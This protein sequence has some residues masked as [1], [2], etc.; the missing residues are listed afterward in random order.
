MKTLP[1][2]CTFTNDY[3]PYL[4]Q[5]IDRIIQPRLW[6]SGSN[7]ADYPDIGDWSQRV[8]TELRREIKRAFI[9]VISRR[10]VGV[11]IYQRDKIEQDILEFKHLSIDEM[12]AGRRIASFLWRQAEIEGVKEFQP[13]LIRCDVKIYRLAVRAFLE[14][15]HYQLVNTADLYSLKSGLDAVYQKE[16]KLIWRRTLGEQKIIIP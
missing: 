4:N 16:V 10:V 5:I 12:L 1:F 8:Y 14:A 3:Y 13:K 9:A 6:F 11:I 15:N 7:F 2:S